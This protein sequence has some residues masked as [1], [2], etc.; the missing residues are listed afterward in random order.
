MADEQEKT[1]EPTSKK[2]EDAK[3][4]GNVP[5]SMDAAGFVALLI[6]VLAVMVAARFIYK[7]LE[8][9]FVY[10]YSFF[11]VGLG[12]RDL[13]AL[14]IVSIKEILLSAVPIAAIVAIAGSLGYLFQFGFIFTVKPLIPD[15]KKINPIKGLKN[16][17]SMQKFIEGLK[18][19]AK[20]GVSFVVGYYI[21]MHFVGELSTVAMFNFA[22][23]LSWL[24]QKAILIA[25]VMLVVFFAFAIIDIIITRYHH[26]KKLRM[27]KQEIKDEFKNIEG[28]PE[29]KARIRRIQQQ[30]SKNRMLSDVQKADVIVTNPTHY[31]VAILYDKSKHAV[32][33]CVAKGV[34][35]L[36]QKIKEEG[37]KHNIFIYEDKPLARELYR[38][39]DVGSEIPQSLYQA[40][41]QVLGFVYKAQGRKL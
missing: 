25:A 40:V 22:D 11:S 17:F 5:K 29:V 7:N 41:A 31:A 28:N 20:V 27:S 4:E 38:L 12:E 16:L 33:I 6:A 3:K 35:F 14:G 10:Y 2:I 36:A 39:V 37:R 24:S 26:F 18:I 1:E 8:S 13:G 30:M 19:T 21:F 15:L 23:Q 34:D 32:P 9:L